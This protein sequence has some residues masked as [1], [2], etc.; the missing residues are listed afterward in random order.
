[1]IRL[2]RCR[3]QEFPKMIARALNWLYKTA[4]LKPRTKMQEYDQRSETPMIESKSGNPNLY[5]FI[6]R[7]TGNVK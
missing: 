5:Q 1:M 3:S 2:G 7:Y 6:A 4:G